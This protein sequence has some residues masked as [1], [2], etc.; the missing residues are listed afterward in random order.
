ML[1]RKPKTLIRKKLVVTLEA[2]VATRLDRIVSNAKA[3]GLEADIEEAL[4]SYLTRAVGQAE[5]ALRAS[6][7][8]SGQ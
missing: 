5:K 6:R 4:S 7:G 1:L 3:A 2:E 8:L